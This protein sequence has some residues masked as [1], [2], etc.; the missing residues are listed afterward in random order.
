MV[1]FES[2]KNEKALRTM[3]RRSLNKEYE[4]C[5]TKPSCDFIFKIL[6][7]AYNGGLHYDVTDMRPYILSFAAKSSHNAD[8]CLKLVNK[9]HFKSE[10]ISEPEES[11]NDLLVFFDCEVFKNLLLINWKFIGEESPVV[12]IDFFEFFR[13]MFRFDM[14]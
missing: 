11:D 4:P 1:N 8:Y 13:N 6:E 9:M 12:Y 7:D 2:I 10:D 5:A 14:Y 3:I